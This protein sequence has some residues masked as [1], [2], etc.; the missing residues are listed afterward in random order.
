MNPAAEYERLLQFF[1]QCPTGLVRLGEDGVIDT[2]NPAAARMLAPA[3]V[4]AELDNLFPVL[5]RLAPA[6]LE[7]IHLDRDRLGP[8]VA[9]GRFLAQTGTVPETWVEFLAVRVEPGRL[10]VVILDVT[11]ERRLAQRERRHALEIND[12]IVQVLVSAEMAL[13]L[14]QVEYGTRLLA[15]ASTAAR[16]WVDEQMRACGG[17]APGNLVVGRPE[18]GDAPSTG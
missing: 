12:R 6:L 15:S 11:T 8:V 5:E 4:D 1:Y 16:R 2:V 13:D 18:P 10:M 14:G 7:H 3:L 9:D 17:A